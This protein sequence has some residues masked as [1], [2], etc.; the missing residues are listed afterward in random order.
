MPMAAPWHKQTL[1]RPPA[2]DGRK[3]AAK[4]GYGRRWRKASQAF[5][6]CHVAR[7]YGHPL[8]VWCKQEGRIVRAT[9]VDHIVPHRGDRKR[10]WDR[11]NWQPMCKRCHDAKTARE[12]GGFGQGRGGVEP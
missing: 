3:S 12:D 10:F 7:D 2:P 4:R 6:D 8:C 9:V 11:T 5:L 1:G